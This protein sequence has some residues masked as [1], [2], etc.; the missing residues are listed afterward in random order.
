MKILK[1][2]SKEIQELFER[3][4]TN[5]KRIEEKV[6]RIIADVRNE[7]DKAILKYTRRFD[8]VKFTPRDLKVSVN[9]INGS[10][11]NI[12]TAFIA[13]LKNIIENIQRYYKKE[14]PKSWRLKYDDGAELGEIFRPIES[15][16]IYVPA[17]TVPLVSSVYMSVVPAKMAGVKKIVIATPPNKHGDVDPH[18]LA[19]ANLLKVDEIYKVGGAQAISALAFGTKT[20]PKVDKIVGP[21]NEYVTEAKR[22][23]FGFVD[24]DM[25]AGPSEVVILA[26]QFS[27]KAYVVQDL[28]AQAEHV[29]GLA[30]LVTTSKKFAK[31]MKDEDVKGYIV[32]TKNID[33]AVEVINRIAPEHLEILIKRPKRILKKIQNAGAIFTGPYS[34]VCIG[35]YVA[36]PSHILPTGGTARFF[37]GLGARSFLKSIHT[38]SYSKKALEK[39]KASVEKMTKIEG[40][41]KHLESYKVRFK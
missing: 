33:Q 6:R 4:Y 12:D 35:D 15:V 5:K 27:D 25:L 2:S 17:G 32:L 20:I 31:T 14:L 18:I 28:M 36:G 21:G 24:I 10:F 11:Q 29:K 26:N 39:E 16:G 19:V 37:S 9:E 13:S 1:L 23:V 7:G 22:Q 40:L 30:V 3:Y 34:P 41:Q 38:I 8:K